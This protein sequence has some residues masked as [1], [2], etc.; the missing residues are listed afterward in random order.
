MRALL[1]FLCFWAAS[2]PGP[3]TVEVLGNLPA[4]GKLSALTADARGTLYGAGGGVVVRLAPGQLP[5]VLAS[6]QIGGMHGFDARFRDPMGIAVDARGL[7][8][9]TDTGENVVDLIGPDGRVTAFVGPL[10]EGNRG[11]GYVDAAGVN[12][13]FSQPTGAAIAPDGS[14]YVADAG[15]HAIRRVTLDAVRAVTTVVGGRRDGIEDGALGSARLSAP[16]YMAF[17]PRGV[18]T[19]VDDDGGTVFLR[20]LKEGSVSTLAR[21][22]SR[23]DPLVGIKGLAVDGAGRIFVV[24][25]GQLFWLDWGQLKPLA[26]VPDA[27]M[28]AFNADGRLCFAAGGQLRAAYFKKP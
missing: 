4:Q 20:Q 12:A 6:E 22:A 26:D 1:A 8:Y 25:R 18:L 3:V 7:V 14:L 21:S 17:G 27:R 11:A 24:S 19:F 9:V 10:R 23:A 13:R 28:P 16:S 15:N 2:G 5:D